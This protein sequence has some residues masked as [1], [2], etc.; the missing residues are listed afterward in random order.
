MKDLASSE[1]LQKDKKKLTIIDELRAI[2]FVINE[3]FLGV[4]IKIAI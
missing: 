1:Q 3:S 4:D 2:E